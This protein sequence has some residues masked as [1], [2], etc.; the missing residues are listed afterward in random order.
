MPRNAT[1]VSHISAVY[2]VV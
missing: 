2:F 1:S